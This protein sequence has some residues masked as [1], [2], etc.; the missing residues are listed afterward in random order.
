[1]AIVECASAQKYKYSQFL[2]IINTKLSRLNCEVWPGLEF[3]NVVRLNFRICNL[4]FWHHLT[5]SK[6]IFFSFKLTDQHQITS[7]IQICVCR[8]MI[9]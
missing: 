3:K 8:N 6:N 5:G 4:L 7:I 9:T 1:M 2:N